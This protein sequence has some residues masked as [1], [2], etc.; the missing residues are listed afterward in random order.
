ALTWVSTKGGGRAVIY[1]RGSTSRE[2]WRAIADFASLAPP[3]KPVDTPDADP[4]R[5]LMAAAASFRGVP[6]AFGG[7]GV[8]TLD[9][10]QYILK[11][12]ERA[13]MPFPAGVRTAESIR[14]AC[15]PI[16]WEAAEPGDLL[17][18][19]HTY[20]PDEPAGPDGRV[21][22]HV[23]I[24][25]GAATQRMWDAHESVEGTGKPGV[26]ETDV[27]TDYWQAHRLEAR[28]APMLSAA[29]PP[30]PGVEQAFRVTDDGVRFR[31]APGLSGPILRTLSR[32]ARDLGQ[33]TPL[34]EADGHQWRQV[35]FGSTV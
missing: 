7:D 22:S 34:V 19:E 14:Q 29:Q 23:G 26:G 6:Y 16:A 11:V 30:V 1:R 12:F 35:R 2:N 10:S 5:E 17:F 31:A 18:F 13:G 4:R 28:R 9:C 20:E 8:N 32:G 27:S 15:V 3:K 24:S 25:Q 21:A 33:G